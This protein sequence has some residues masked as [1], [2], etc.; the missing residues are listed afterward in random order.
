M[1]ASNSAPILASQTATSSLRLAIDILFT[2]LLLTFSW[3]PAITIGTFD[4]RFADVLLVLFVGVFLGKWLFKG[5]FPL[6]IREARQKP[7]LTILFLF[8]L[9][10]VTSLFVTVTPVLTVRR[11]VRVWLLLMLVIG[12]Q[13]LRPSLR[14]VA[15]LLSLHILGQSLIA[16]AQAILQR[17]VGLYWLGEKK[18][19]AQLGYNVLDTGSR[20]ILRIQ[21]LAEHPNLLAITLVVPLLVILV[22]LIFPEEISGSTS[23]FSRTLPAIA[24]FFGII[25][26]FFTFSR[27]ATLGG[28]IGVG[29]LL[30]VGKGWTTARQNRQV[31]NARLIRCVFFL[32]GMLVISMMLFAY[33][34]VILSRLDL[35]G[36]ILERTSVTERAVQN[37]I[38]WKMV[39]ASPLVGVGAHSARERFT[40]FFGAET[41]ISHTIHNTVLL[42]SAEL[43]LPAGLL[44]LILLLTPPIYAIRRRH[45]LS[46]PTLA[47]TIALVPYLITDFT[48][49]ASYDTP[50]GSLLHWLLLALWIEST[51]TT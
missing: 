24:L 9:W 5:E 14:W 12:I 45:T 17:D 13:D 39:Q 8:A 43:G 7:L 4:L 37:H 34:D 15:N 49:P 38:G 50:V 32:M 11:I 31:R 41:P 47:Y 19:M 6:K 1:T 27:A 35:G 18:Q 40:E 20:L 16:I 30:F 51:S 28:V 46:V 33:R 22:Y 36:S 21:G 25:A 42:I 48:S 44:W 2:S 3:G 29:L 23:S 26:L 10:T